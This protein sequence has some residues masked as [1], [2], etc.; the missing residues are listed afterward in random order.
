MKV[1]E[2]EM[3]KNLLDTAAVLAEIEKAFV[4]LS[5]GQM[6]APPVGL[7][8]TPKGITHI[9]YG[10][11][12]GD[13]YFVIKIA[14][15]YHGNVEKGLPSGSGMMLVL[16]ANT[17]DT[18]AILDDNGWLTDV[19]TALAGAIAVKHLA[20][21]RIRGVGILGTGVQA[22]LQAAYIKPF[23]D[24]A[25]LYL[26]GRNADRQ[27]ACARDIEQQGYTVNAC[28]LETL[29][30]NCNV[31]I[32]TT[33][34]ETPLLKADSLS[35]DTLI[36][37]VGADAPGKQELDAALV[38][39][40]AQIVCDKVDQCLD[41]GELQTAHQAGRLETAKIRELGD[42]I[43]NGEQQRDIL[44]L[45]DLTGVAA[46]D[47]AIAQHVYNKWRNSM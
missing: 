15:S 37:A 4:S 7:L 46:Q 8:T 22:R 21:S 27:S 1:F 19:R 18:L 29:A 39:E 33:P 40:C 24:T 12:A 17:G 16:D 10:H 13:D 25:P 35:D 34:S 41:H 26:W 28:D 3:I 36:I 11:I 23:I 2:L 44:T 5:A 30:K 47:I 20:P 32:T 45:V 42:I 14:S 43:Q 9:K 6:T 31:I 38:L